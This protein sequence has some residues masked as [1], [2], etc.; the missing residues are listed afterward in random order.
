MVRESSASI[1]TE[2]QVGGTCDDRAKCTS[3]EEAGRKRTA[4]RREH[5][6]AEGL[7]E[8]HVLAVG[9]VYAWVCS[10]RSTRQRHEAGKLEALSLRGEQLEGGQ[11]WLGGE[12]E[13]YCA[14]RGS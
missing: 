7:G 2:E 14:S 12:T 10:G 3:G 9:E 1:N 4:D 13:A 8:L 5:D 6:L 11:V